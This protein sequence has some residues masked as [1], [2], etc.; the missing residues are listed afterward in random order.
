MTATRAWQHTLVLLV[1]MLPATGFALSAEA[2][3]N[4]KRAAVAL[5]E[6]AEEQGRSDWH[7]ASELH[8]VGQST[9]ALR[10]AAE[11]L[12]EPAEALAPYGYDDVDDWAEEGGRIYRAL[13]ASQ[14]GDPRELQSQFEAAIRQIEENPHLEDAAKEGVIADIERQR[15]RVVGFFGA[16]TSEERRAVAPYKQQLMEL[17]GR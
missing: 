9:D 13:L 11:A 7:P 4:W 5:K 1:G 12:A 10:Q 8:G 17:M 6:Q 15:E 16:V 14:A 3:E 2:V